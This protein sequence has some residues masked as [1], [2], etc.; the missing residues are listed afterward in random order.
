MIRSWSDERKRVAM[1]RGVSLVVVL[2]AAA[3]CAPAADHSHAPS[4][5]TWTASSPVSASA[6]AR[7][8]EVGEVP[9]GVSGTSRLAAAFVVAAN[10]SDTRTDRSPDD[11]WRRAAPLAT[12]RL[13]AT[14]RKPHRES[15]GL[16]WSDLVAHDGWVSV[17]VLD[18]DGGGSQDAA[19]PS[20]SH[21]SEEGVYA[22][23]FQRV[24]HTGPRE[25]R[26]PTS[27]MWLVTMR[28]GLVDKF[29]AGL[30]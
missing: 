6:V 18:V 20:P 2:L 3:G 21:T 22:V 26:D 4:T 5:P 27:Y 23:T 17:D 24:L 30:A 16:E 8:Q 15:G 28:H 13:Q 1:K 29:S 10:S 12:P 9:D 25:R 19:P 7:G 11:A 14:L